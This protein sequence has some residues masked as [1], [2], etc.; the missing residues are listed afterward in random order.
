MF[1]ANS[2]GKALSTPAASFTHTAVRLAGRSTHVHHKAQ[3]SFYLSLRFIGGCIALA[4]L[5]VWAAYMCCTLRRAVE[6]DGF[7]ALP[8]QLRPQIP[9][10]AVSP[11]AVD[12]G[13]EGS[14]NAAIG[15]NHCAGCAAG[16]DVQQV[17]DNVAAQAG[18]EVLGSTENV[19]RSKLSGLETADR[20]PSEQVADAWHNEPR[21]QPPEPG[22]TLQQQAQQSQQQAS[23]QQ[24]ASAAGVQGASGSH[25]EHAAAP[26]ARSGGTLSVASSPHQARLNEL[27]AEQ[28]VLEAGMKDLQSALAPGGSAA[29]QLQLMMAEQKRKMD[30]VTAEI[31][32]Y[33][34]EILDSVASASSAQTTHGSGS[35]GV[36]SGAV[37]GG[38]AAES[39]A[40]GSEDVPALAAP[41]ASPP[42]LVANI[43]AG[44]P[45][46]AGTEVDP[47]PQQGFNQQ[48][49]NAASQVVAS[50]HSAAVPAAS[51]TGMEAAAPGLATSPS[52]PV[53]DAGS[54]AATGSASD[55]GDSFGMLPGEADGVAVV[56]D[57]TMLLKV[58]KSSVEGGSS[59]STASDAGY[60][61]VKNPFYHH[62]SHKCKPLGRVLA[63]PMEV[64]VRKGIQKLYYDAAKGGLAKKGANE[65]IAGQ[66]MDGERVSALSGAAINAAAYGGPNQPPLPPHL[67]SALDQQKRQQ[68]LQQQ[69][70]NSDE[71]VDERPGGVREMNVQRSV[72]ETTSAPWHLSWPRFYKFEHELWF[73][74]YEIAKWRRASRCDESSP[75][76]LIPM[77]KRQAEM[78]AEAVGGSVAAVA[79]MTA[80]GTEKAT[81][82]LMEKINERKEEFQR[83]TFCEEKNRNGAVVEM[84]DVVVAGT[85]QFEHVCSQDG[86]VEMLLTN[87]A[88]ALSYGIPPKHASTLAGSTPSGSSRN[89]VFWGDIAASWTYQHWIQNNL[90]KIGRSAMFVDGLVGTAA[91]VELRKQVAHALGQTV[92]ETWWS[93]SSSSNSVNPPGMNAAGAASP[94]STAGHLRG[95][96]PSSESALSNPGPA[97]PAV[98]PGHGDVFTPGVVEVQEVIPERYPIVTK[99]HDSIGWGVADVRTEPIQ[100]D[101]LVYACQTPPL[102]PHLWQVAQTTVLRVEPK[103]I[104]KRNKIVY[105][106]RNKGL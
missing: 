81:S 84:L 63:S 47:Q 76:E 51:A 36:N 33:L 69:Q 29:Q 78:Q 4:T 75:Y 14:A 42:S 99:L 52:Q 106:G 74:E 94:P 31:M 71:W 67:L 27:M 95:S 104:S 65:G 92:N 40:T 35:S 72:T 73:A 103:P 70:R 7:S 62:A 89:T 2:G 59:G 43:G 55:T 12:S 50:D 85:G 105:C 64:V 8:R 100:A 48:A 37:G 9:S 17:R 90:P 82:A 96:P 34:P 53:G 60:T 56:D 77:L 54:A 91:A 61:Y 68:Q 98:P 11:A 1:R 3:S 93:G 79:G 58:K 87:G 101:R 15:G 13:H 83:F 28:K 19:E 80:A 32:K 41:P 66:T 45:V 46:E 26:P 25:D 23:L 5:L 102:H 86:H 22:L 97:T 24:S 88:A 38:A 30:I 57:I 20:T 39:A 10:P 16:S 21:V 44:L 18:A 49:S 6:A